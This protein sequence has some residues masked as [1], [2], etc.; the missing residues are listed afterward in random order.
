MMWVKILVLALE[1]LNEDIILDLEIE[2][3]AT[4][5]FAERGTVTIT[6][7]CEDIPHLDAVAS[8]MVDINYWD[9]RQQ[10]KE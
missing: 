10:C 8:V 5:S 1:I 7:A 9:C 6:H 2:A 4:Q 3:D